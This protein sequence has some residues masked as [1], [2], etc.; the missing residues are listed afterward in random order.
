LIDASSYRA[1]QDLID[2]TVTRIL[3]L[4]QRWQGL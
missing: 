2:Q 1:R 4:I 3:D